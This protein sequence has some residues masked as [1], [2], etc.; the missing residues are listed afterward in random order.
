MGRGTYLGG[1]TVVRNG[2]GFT[3]LDD[4]AGYKPG[5]STLTKNQ[6]LARERHIIAKSAK[7]MKKMTD[8]TNEIRREIRN[9]ISRYKR[10]LKD[11]ES[12]A[13]LPVPDEYSKCDNVKIITGV[14]AELERVLREL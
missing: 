4:D 5:P 10:L 1:N 7:A 13:K 14:I 3:P 2:F 11:A 12:V 6:Q 9:D 8:L